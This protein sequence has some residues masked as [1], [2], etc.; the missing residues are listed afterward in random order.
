MAVAREKLHAHR[1][2]LAVAKAPVKLVQPL[3]AT[4]TTPLQEKL[5]ISVKARSALVPG[6]GRSMDM[7]MD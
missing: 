6:D 1:K 2:K 4:Q 3:S 7:S 5:K